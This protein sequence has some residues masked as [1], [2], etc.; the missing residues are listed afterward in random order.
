MKRLV[1]KALTVFLLIASLS[2]MSI[3]WS[4]AA[5]YTCKIVVGR[6]DYK[7]SAQDFVAVEAPYY[8]IKRPKAWEAAAGNPGYYSRLANEDDSAFI[9]IVGAP[10]I[11]SQEIAND[12]LSIFGMEKLKRP[13]YAYKTEQLDWDLY[14]LPNS[15]KPFCAALSSYQGIS[16]VALLAANSGSDLQDLAANVMRPLLASFEPRYRPERIKRENTI[17]L[18]RHAN[19]DETKENVPLSDKGH[20][21]ARALA[22]LLRDENIDAIYVTPALRTQQTAAPLAE[23]K[24]IKPQVIST[25]T[26]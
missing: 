21:R 3:S 12:L 17:F 1:C 14:S 11:S 13:Q 4:V 6:D 8:H 22:A 15:D 7:I 16:Y 9:W 20:E 23:E 2:M 24:G 18:L 5:S 26:R 10:G 19:K 25:E